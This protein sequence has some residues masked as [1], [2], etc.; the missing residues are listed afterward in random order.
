M[1][2]QRSGPS[3]SSYLAEMAEHLRPLPQ[4]RRAEE[5]REVRDHLESTAQALGENGFPED[6]AV[7]AAIE[8]F[9]PARDAARRFVAA[10]RRGERKRKE[11]VMRERVVF[12]AS[13]AVVVLAAAWLLFAASMTYRMLTP[14]GQVLIHASEGSSLRVQNGAIQVLAAGS[15]GTGVERL[16]GAFVPAVAV[17]F[18]VILGFAVV[19]CCSVLSPRRTA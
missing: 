14:R 9:G 13:L 3:L 1:H 17:P 16:G 10:W 12:G 7:R 15:S 11:N 2:S 6:E 18:V 4:A 19:G 5:L 8:Q